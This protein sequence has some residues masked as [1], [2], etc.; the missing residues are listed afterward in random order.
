[1]SNLPKNSAYK[2]SLTFGADGIT[3]QNDNNT[4]IFRAN[5]NSNQQ[6]NDSYNPQASQQPFKMA[7]DYDIDISGMNEDDPQAKTHILKFK[8][9]K[10]HELSDQ[11]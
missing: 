10:I 1:M 8:Q 6:N 4:G 7:R 2:S 11:R 9:Q 5:R 3:T